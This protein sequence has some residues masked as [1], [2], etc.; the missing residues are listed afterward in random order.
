[1]ILHYRPIVLHPI[2]FLITLTHSDKRVSQIVEAALL[3]P[4]EIMHGVLVQDIISIV[5]RIVFDWQMLLV[6]NVFLLTF[7]I[8]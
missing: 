8:F 6:I 3:L 5:I 2:E 7:T 1:M 4:L